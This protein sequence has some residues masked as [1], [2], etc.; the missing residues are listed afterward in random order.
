MLEQL[1]SLRWT[2]IASMLGAF[3]AIGLGLLLVRR[4][5]NRQHIERYRDEPN[6]GVPDERRTN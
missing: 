6:A 3:G 4:A 2:Q 5:S 1:L